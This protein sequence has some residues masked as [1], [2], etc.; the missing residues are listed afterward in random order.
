VTGL[1]RQELRITAI[2]TDDYGIVT[3]RYGAVTGRYGQ[4]VDW[5]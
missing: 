3:Y 5:L 1:Q 2:V 4:S